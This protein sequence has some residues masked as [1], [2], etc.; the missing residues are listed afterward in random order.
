MTTQMT[1][2]ATTLGDQIAQLTTFAS[3]LPDGKRGPFLGRLKS[4]ASIGTTQRQAMAEYCINELAAMGELDKAKAYWEK[5]QAEGTRL[6]S[7]E[8][9]AH[10]ARHAVGVA[11]MRLKAATKRNKLDKLIL[12]LVQLA[13]HADVESI[14]ELIGYNE[15]RMALLASNLHNDDYAVI[16]PFLSLPKREK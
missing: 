3:F 10:A 9:T 2:Q 16:A 11:T 8:Q 4:Y 5:S 15:D 1:L 6:V 7:V 13:Q 12:A 14:D